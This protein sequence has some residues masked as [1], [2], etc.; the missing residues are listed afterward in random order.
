MV[1]INDGAFFQA[2]NVAD[3]LVLEQTYKSLDHALNSL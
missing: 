1:T 2:Y 3:A